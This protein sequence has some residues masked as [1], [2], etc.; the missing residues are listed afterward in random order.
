MN[1]DKPLPSFNEAATC[2]KCG[3]DEINVRYCIAPQPL[4]KC[5]FVLRFGSNNREHLHRVCNRCH[6]EW[7]EACLSDVQTTVES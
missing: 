6:Y 2:P 5:W 4:K 3:Y 7:L 1:K